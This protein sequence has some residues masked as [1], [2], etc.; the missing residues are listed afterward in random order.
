MHLMTRSS[1]GWVLTI[2][3][4]LGFKNMDHQL[5][6][7]LSAMF[8]RRLVMFLHFDT[9]VLQNP[10][11]EASC[12]NEVYQLSFFPHISR[13]PLSRG[14]GWPGFTNFERVLIYISDFWGYFWSPEPIKI[15]TDS[16]DD[17]LHDLIIYVSRSGKFTA[18][19]IA[20]ICTMN[21]KNTCDFLRPLYTYMLCRRL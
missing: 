10:R 4:F 5:S 19:Y 16:W 6:N 18:F 8:L 1:S 15:S 2:N 12:L 14:G 7:A 9:Y 3:I 17:V 21:V 20:Y 11:K 13:V